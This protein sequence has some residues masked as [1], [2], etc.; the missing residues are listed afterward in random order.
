VKR[1]GADPILAEK[2]CTKC[3][4]VQIT[5]TRNKICLLCGGALQPAPENIDR[6]YP[7]RSTHV[8]PAALS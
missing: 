2:I 7:T 6:E 3:R 1:G 8:D 5:W 4:V